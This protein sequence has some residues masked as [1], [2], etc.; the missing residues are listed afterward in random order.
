MFKSISFKKNLNT[1][2]IKIV[3]SKNISAKKV[4]GLYS[5][6][7]WQYREIDEIEASF[8]KSILVVSAW[9]N[10]IL[11]G[12]GRATGDGIFNATIWDVAV[13]PLYQKNKIGT[14]II[15]TMLTKLYDCGIPLITLYTESPKKDFYS[16]LGFESNSHIIGMFKYNKRHN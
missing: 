2:A 7:G 10:E 9:D 16:K 4:Q 13:R 11:I 6:V 5:S 8:E 1:D 14:L 15:K 12:I 3:E